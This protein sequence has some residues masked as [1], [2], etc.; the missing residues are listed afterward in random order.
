MSDTKEDNAQL[1]LTPS[2]GRAFL[3]L[4][5]FEWQTRMTP[6]K[7]AQSAALVVVIPIL[8]FI[9]LK[10][11]Q[12]REF[13]DWIVTYHLFLMLPI[14]CLSVFG[15]V[16]RDELQSD[17]LGFII[18]RPIKRYSLLILKYLCTMI[19]S[20]VLVLLCGLLF[21]VVALVHGYEVDP[22]MIG[23]FL[24]VQALAVMAY[25]A[26]SCLLG[27]LT[28]KYMVLGIVYGLVVEKGIGSIPTNIH[29]LAISHHLKSI[30]GNHQWMSD[31]FTLTGE[32]IVPAI[33]WVILAAATFL[34][35][36][37]LLFN[38]LEY[39]HSDEMQK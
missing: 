30:L 4:W 23:L 16:I 36:A 3:G 26:I 18:T 27:L 20:Q 15:P 37:A 11:G 29:S 19:W 9:A 33:G 38:T 17:T 12:K 28:K 14:Y 34:S 31:Q 24:L 7:L 8:M 25:G 21:F 13:I 22:T 1:V 6:G 5:S 10:E 39:N 32:P 35:V 2:L